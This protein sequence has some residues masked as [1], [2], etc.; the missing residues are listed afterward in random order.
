MSEDVREAFLNE[1][2]KD[3]ISVRIR[4]RVRF[5]VRFRGRVRARPQRSRIL[6]RPYVKCGS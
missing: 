6:S 4:I 3:P 2:T 5:R 1:L